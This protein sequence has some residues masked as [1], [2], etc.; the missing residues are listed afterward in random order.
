M[1]TP[2]PNA[3]PQQDCPKC[4]HAWSRH[5]LI[6]GHCTVRTVDASGNF[7]GCDCDAKQSVASQPGEILGI[8]F[9]DSEPHEG[10]H[11]QR[12]DC[13]GWKV[14]EQ[15]EICAT[16]GG[17]G[18]SA[19]LDQCA[20]CKGRRF[21]LRPGEIGDG[22]LPTLD[23]HTR[24]AW[25]EQIDGLFAI[26]IPGEDIPWTAARY[27][28]RTTPTEEDIA[29]ARKHVAEMGLEA[30]PAPPAPEWKYRSIVPGEPVPVTMPVAPP[31]V[32]QQDDW[33]KLSVTA[34]AAEN[35]SVAEYIHESETC[36][37]GLCKE[38]PCKMVGCQCQCHKS[39][40]GERPETYMLRGIERIKPGE[41]AQA[42]RYILCIERQLA[43]ALAERDAAQTRISTLNWLLREQ[44]ERTI[45]AESSLS[46]AQREIERL[47]GVKAE[48]A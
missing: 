46:A 25:H 3:Q 10:R 9:T 45:A 14:L 12:P 44:E 27:C 39:E 15:G 11:A 1:T 13:V 16:C 31:E 23:G 41:D 38:I 36:L 8:C 7:D 37:Q 32:G 24:E 26:A 20:A 35:P 30:I 40:G 33:R 2:P 42:V 4:G 29:W 43:Q 6:L 47:G 21:A 48:G 17:S 19:S 22:A 34:I 5:S 28:W 18:L